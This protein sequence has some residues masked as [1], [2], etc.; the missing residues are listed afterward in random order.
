MNFDNVFD[1]EEDFKVVA[2][3]EGKLKSSIAAQEEED[4]DLDLQNKQ[5]SFSREEGPHEV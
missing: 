2:V 5:A 3:A 1:L 4:L